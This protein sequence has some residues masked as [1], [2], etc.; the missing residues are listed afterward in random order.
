MSER[1]REMKEA[2]ATLTLLWKKWL[3]RD[4]AGF[5]I[6]FPFFFCGLFP[7]FLQIRNGPS[8]KGWRKASLK[9][10]MGSEILRSS[11]LPPWF[12][13]SPHNIYV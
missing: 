6:S 5:F 1:E 4:E 7:S 9:K 12:H 10:K 3:N 11:N 8:E 2:G 13:F